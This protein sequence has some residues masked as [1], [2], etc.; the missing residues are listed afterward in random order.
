VFIV[1]EG[2]FSL[3]KA[4]EDEEEGIPRLFLLFSFEEGW[5]T[6]GGEDAAVGFPEADLDLLPILLTKERAF[7]LAGL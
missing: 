4:L 7:D 2:L 5:S 3:S 1:D 6:E